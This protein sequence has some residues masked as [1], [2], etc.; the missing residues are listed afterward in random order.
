MPRAANYVRPIYLSLQVLREA[1][2]DRFPVNLKQILRHYHIRLMTYEDFC[3]C[4]ECDISVCFNLFGKDGATIA[5]RGRYLIVYN[6]QQTP[7]ERIRFTLAHEL[8]HIFHRHHNELGVE[9]LQRMWVEKHLYD[10]MEDE[11]NCFAR[12]LLCP[13]IAVQTV[14]RSHGFVATDYD[15]GQKRNVWFRVAVAPCLPNLP[16]GLTDY[17]LVQQSFQVTSS[18]AKIRCSFLKEDLRNSPKASAEEIVSRIMF[19]TQWRCR[20]C[21]ALRLEDTDYC[22]HCGTKGRYGF[23]SATS[24][25]PKPLRLRY[26]GFH[27]SSCPVCGNDDLPQDDYYC[28]ICGNP[29]ANPCIPWRVRNHSISHLIYLAE[30]GSV[31]LN[32]PGARYCLT[33]GQ[34]TL[35]GM[36]ELKSEM[37]VESRNSAST[38]KRLILYDYMLRTGYRETE[39]KTDNQGGLPSVKYGPNIPCTTYN[40]Q[41]RVQKCPKCLNEDNDA[42]ADFCIMCGTSL[43]NVCDGI[44]S[45]YDDQIYTHSN[46]ANARFCRLCGK[47]TAYSRLPILPPYQVQLRIQAKQDALR[48][49]LAEMEIDEDMFWRMNGMDAEPVGDGEDEEFAAFLAGENNSDDGEDSATTANP[50]PGQWSIDDDGELPF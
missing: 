35:Y 11:A 28:R 6:K 2:I 38:A 7:R 22:Y 32:P 1:G 3:A 18:A 49:E 45:D 47:P 4:H 25:S 44:E 26:S 19:S 33:C 24:P 13:A 42:D 34:P 16:S 46:P 29:V 9:T 12:N 10:V 40:N 50:I 48:R 14:L 20:K 39:I 27:F 15:A 30:N 8:G 23:V 21:G 41:Y 31:H 43:T 37:Q 36:S 5:M 17:F